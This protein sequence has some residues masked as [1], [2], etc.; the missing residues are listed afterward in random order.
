MTAQYL[1]EPA[2]NRLFAGRN[3]NIQGVAHVNRCVVR[4]GLGAAEEFPAA[5]VQGSGNW[6]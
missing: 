3:Q 2:K 4:K 1:R 6:L 5:S